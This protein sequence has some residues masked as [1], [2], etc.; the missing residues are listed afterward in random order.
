MSTQVEAQQELTNTLLQELVKVGVGGKYKDNDDYTQKI[1]EELDHEERMIRGGKERYNKIVVD[2]QAK[3]QE[4]TTTYGLYQQQK[5]IGKL[6]DLI[7]L[8]IE[9]IEKGGAGRH[10]I[11]T[12]LVSQCL[13]KTAFNSDTKQLSN[14]H[15]I[16][17]KCSLIV[18]KNVIDGISTKCTLNQLS[19]IIGNALMQEA[20]IILFKETNRKQYEQIN[21]RLSGKNIPQ[22]TNRYLYKKN[23]WTY[24]MNKHN[25]M[26]DNW[27]KEHR[28][29]LGVE[30]VHLCRLLGLVSVEGRKEHK[31]KTI[32]YVEATDKMINE[33]KN[34]NIKNEA[35]TPTYLPMIMP[36]KKWTN[37]HDGGYYGKKHNFEN[38]VDEVKNAL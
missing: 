32:V 22:K 26:F 1:Q 15:N 20:K 12:K 37:P 21:K 33:I 24:C 5:Y 10:T 25:L 31:H 2:A 28:L 18:L 38:K 35:L 19:I 13:P 7:H 8:K 3:R 4:S 14:N 36:P 11:A 9:K 6:S 29:H 23:V 27:P 16:W 34:F 30:M 17:D